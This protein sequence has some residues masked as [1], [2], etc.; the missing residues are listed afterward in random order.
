MPTQA[1]DERKSFYAKSRKEWRNWLAKNHE[2]EKFVWLII[3]HKESK[4]PSVYYEE[5][6]EEALCFGWIDSKGNKR[7]SESFYLFFAQR[8]PRSNWSKINKERVEKMTQQ[9]LMTENGQKLIDLAKMKGTWTAL[10]QIDDLIIPADLKKI[11][12]KNKK[13]SKNFEAFSSSSKKIILNWILSAKRPETREQRLKQTVE[14]AAK[15]I[16]ANHYRQ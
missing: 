14:L 13:A 5:A 3:Y 12:D 15:N 2:L 8:N 7:D 9:G 1:K 11:L 4:T 16:K 6:V 10:E